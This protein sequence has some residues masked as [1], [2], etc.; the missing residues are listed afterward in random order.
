MDS[1]DEWYYKNYIMYQSSSDDSSDDESDSLVATLIVNE[2][3]EDAAGV[4]RVVAGLFSCLGPEQV[5]WPCPALW[6]LLSF[7]ETHIPSQGFPAPFP[8]EK[9]FVQPYPVG[10]DAF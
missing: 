1:C 2:Y 6:G 8:D 3:I 10:G 9:I 7:G 5:S 4:P